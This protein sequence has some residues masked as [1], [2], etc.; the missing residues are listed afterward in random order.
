[1]NATFPVALR[2]FVPAA[3]CAVFIA[4]P[5]IALGYPATGSARPND[6]S[7]PGEWDIEKYDVCLKT[8]KATSACCEESGGVWNGTFGSP[9]WTC[10]APAAAPASQQPP[11]AEVPGREPPVVGQQQPGATF[12]PAPPFRGTP[13]DPAP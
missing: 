7:S 9:R 11:A 13:V 6:G 12:A 4:L 10:V 5:V 3:V 2:R 8:G 1:M